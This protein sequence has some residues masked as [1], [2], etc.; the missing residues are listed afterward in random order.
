MAGDADLRNQPERMQ[1]FQH[2]QIKNAVTVQ[3]SQVYRSSVVS[4]S[5]SSTGRQMLRSV[6]W[7]FTP[8][9]N[10]T[11]LG[12]SMYVPSTSRNR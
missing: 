1:A 9:P 12:P 5:L 4:R 7:K 3:N 10:R 6:T 2:I 11:S 8:L